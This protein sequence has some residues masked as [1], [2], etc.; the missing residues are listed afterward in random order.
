MGIL[1]GLLEGVMGEARA[2]SERLRHAEDE[3]D[4]FNRDLLGKIAG[5][6]SYE[7][8]VRQRA[9]T[10]LLEMASSPRSKKSGSYLSRLL[11]TNPLEVHPGVRDFYRFLETPEEIPGLKVRTVASQPNP[12]A[13]AAAPPP[14]SQGAAAMPPTP[15]GQPGGGPPSVANLGSPLGPQTGPPGPPPGPLA[16]T[17]G[18]QQALHAINAQT[19]VETQ[20]PPTV[21][22]RRILRDPYEVA[23]TAAKA[24]TL[25]D[26]EGKRAGL[27]AAGATPEQTREALLRDVG[28]RVGVGGVGSIQSVAGEMPDGSPAYGILD[29]RPASPTFGKYIDPDTEEVLVN[30]R[31]RT[32]TGSTSMGAANEAQAR[33]LYG[34]PYAQ[35]QPA[36]QQAVLRAVQQNTAT[37]AGLRTDAVNVANAGKPL[38]PEERL[39]QEQTLRNNLERIV[40]G[41]RTTL[42][43]AQ[44]VETAYAQLAKNYEAGK[45]IGAQ[46]QA[47]IQGFNR[48]LDELSTVREAE[49]ERTPTGQ[50]LWNRFQGKLDQLAQGGA[51]LGIEELANV[52]KLARELA[53]GRKGYLRDQAA[54]TRNTIRS[55]RLEERNVLSPDTLAILNEGVQ[56]PP[57]VTPGALPGSTTPAPNPGAG[58]PPKVGDR[59]GQGTSTVGAMAP[60]LALAM[61]K[62][63]VP[64]GQPWVKIT[65]T[66]PGGQPEVWRKYPDGR[67]EKQ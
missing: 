7:P 11:G 67:V 8:E 21:V 34:K 13:P 55:Y 49:Y 43:Q 30:F 27:N 28:G 45:P 4:T 32:T 65:Y 29:K 46:S 23:S 31:P 64:P 17:G 9:A 37:T 33:A 48:I 66:P 63:G 56:P 60:D 10:A 38:T 20:G 52:V 19:P 51:G 47:V 50:S 41:A 18:I 26:L 15:A 2:N 62:I 57:Q 44:V 36:E 61:E 35:L 58:A 42:Q 40:Q 53:E 25:G 54:V 6:D 24:K 59:V 1:S 14:P 12:P 39:T 5:D 22:P 16:V 3:Q